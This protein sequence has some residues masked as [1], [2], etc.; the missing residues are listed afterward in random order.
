MFWGQHGR[1]QGGL[2]PAWR[3]SSG[4]G[5]EGVRMP[6]GPAAVFPAD[7]H[8]RIWGWGSPAT[9]CGP[10]AGG[11]RKRRHLFKNGRWR[12]GSALE[13]MRRPSPGA[14]MLLHEK[15]AQASPAVQK[16]PLRIGFRHP[17]WEQQK[18]RFL[19]F[20]PFRLSFS[21]AGEKLK[22]VTIK[23]R[24]IDKAYRFA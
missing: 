9:R 4:G 22:R 20:S 8:G 2:P 12:S 5:A 14:A 7:S 11:G 18:I 17:L 16:Q 6:K 24:Y 10:F 1:R 13:D 3:F 23:A 21:H 19:F 15:G